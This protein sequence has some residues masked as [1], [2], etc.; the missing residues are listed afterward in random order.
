MHTNLLKDLQQLE[1]LVMN[2]GAKRRRAS[3][4]ASVSKKRRRSSKMR[5]G[6]RKNP[7]DRHFTIVSVNGKAVKQGDGGRYGITKL[8]GPS[9]AVKKAYTELYRKM[10]LKP[11]KSKLKIVIR[12]VTRSGLRDEMKGVQKAR[13][14]GPYL[15]EKVKLPKP[16]KV[17]VAKGKRGWTKTHQTKV[18]K[19]KGS[20]KGGAYLS[21]SRKSSKKASVGRK[22]R[23]KSSKKG[24]ARRKSSKKASLSRRRKS[25]RKSS[26]KGGGKWGF[27]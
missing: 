25:R 6:K 26:K 24:G 23:R 1:T 16:V 5:G 3:K 18:K 7:V 20:A 13:V 21:K 15:V 2:G 14:Y 8:Q 19:L 27:F 17:K 4:S 22:A 12:E 9:N 10:K 11:T